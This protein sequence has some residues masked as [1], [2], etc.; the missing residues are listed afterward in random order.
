MKRTRTTIA[1]AL[2]LLSFGIG[3][4]VQALNI[5]TTPAPTTQEI[6]A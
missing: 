2:L 6:T 1:T 3:N 5:Q 4:G